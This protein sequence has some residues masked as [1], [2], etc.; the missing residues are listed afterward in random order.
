MRHAELCVFHICV[1]QIW[2]LKDQRHKS[3]QVSVDT[4]V[5]MNGH[6]QSFTHGGTVKCRQVPIAA[7]KHAGRCWVEDSVR[8]YGFLNEVWDPSVARM[9]G[10]EQ[11]FTQ[12]GTVKCQQVPIA[13]AKHAGRC[14]V[15]DSVRCYGFLNEVWDPS[16]ARALPALY[17][18]PPYLGALQPRCSSHL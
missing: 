15:E 1:F 9:N 13:A 4:D 5:R 16:V 12:G 2:K 3:R 8:C 10:H 14:W 11:S 6:E 18:F 17:Q 7:T